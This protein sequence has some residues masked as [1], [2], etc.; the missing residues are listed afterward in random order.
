MLIKSCPTW[1]RHLG[2]EAV[3]LHQQDADATLYHFYKA[4]HLS[5]EK[6]YN[7][8][9]YYP[10]THNESRTDLGTKVEVLNIGSRHDITA[11]LSIFPIK[12]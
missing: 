12:Q 10:F 2:N 4:L 9:D 8:R 1:H 3:I 6:S 7:T 11:L 5:T